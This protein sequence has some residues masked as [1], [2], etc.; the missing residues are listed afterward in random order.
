LCKYE[1]AL[2]D[3]INAIEI[4][5][6]DSRAYLKRGI[7][8]YNLSKYEEAL[9]VFEHGLRRAEGESNTKLTLFVEWM[10]KSSKMVPKPATSTPATQ[11]STKEQ[12]S[13]PTQ[14]PPVQQTYK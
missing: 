2:N 11:E 1:E 14:V 3:A 4:N 10:D 8:L 9:Q 6:N 7:A 5:E 12:S 13:T